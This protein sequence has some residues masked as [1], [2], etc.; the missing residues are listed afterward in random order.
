MIIDNSSNNSYLLREGRDFNNILI[1]QIE[2]IIRNEFSEEQF[3]GFCKDYNSK[4]FGGNGAWLPTLLYY[5]IRKDKEG[6]LYVFFKNTSVMSGERSDSSYLFCYKVDGTFWGF[7]EWDTESD[8]YEKRKEN[9]EKYNY[10]Y[11]NSES[12]I[13]LGGYKLEIEFIYTKS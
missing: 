10:I 8:S 6:N 13:R 5:E 7:K 9:R 3:K 12:L 2:D 11:E 4:Y 1:N